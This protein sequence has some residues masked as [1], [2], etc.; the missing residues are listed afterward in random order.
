MGGVEVGLSEGGVS[1][2]DTNGLHEAEGLVH[3]GSKLAVARSFLGILNEVQVPCVKATD[4]GVPTGGEGAENVECL[5]RLVVG[6]HHVVGI[7]S[8]GISGE[9]LIVDDIAAVGGKRNVALHFV[10]IGSGLGELAC[11]ATDLHDRNPHRVREDD[12][13]LQD[14]PQLL[15]DVVGGELLERFGAVAGLEEECVA[16][17]HLGQ[18]GLQ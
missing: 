5:G 16:G 8:A 10:W 18:A 13:H 14:D 12:G 7:V 6:L 11:H 1:S 9:L 17:C 4:I 15:P 2:V 3:L